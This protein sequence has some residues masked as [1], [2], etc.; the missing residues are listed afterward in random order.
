MCTP[1]RLAAPAMAPPMSPFKHRQRGFSYLFVIFLISLTAMGLLAGRV[2]EVTEQQRERER[3]L[4]FIGRQFHSAL[5]SYAQSG[6]G[7]PNNLTAYPTSLDDLL[8]D[9]R[10]PTIR[11]HLR[12]IFVDPMTGSKDWGLQRAGDRIVGIYSRSE[13]KPLKQSGFDPDESAFE[14]ASK[15]SDWVFGWQGASVAPV[16]QGH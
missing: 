14:G 10:V 4:L 15:Y 3:E 6:G 12:K 13:K 2:V 8:E 16:V 5:A 11:R 1:A 7:G 9:K